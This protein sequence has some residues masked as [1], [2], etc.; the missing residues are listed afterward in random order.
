MAGERILVV[1]DEGLIQQLCRRILLKNG[2]EVETA[3]N[4]SHALEMN[5][6]SSYDILLTDIKMPGMSG[7]ELIEKVKERQPEIAAIVITGY[8]SVDTA[9]ESLKLGVMGFIIKPFTPDALLVTI[10]NVLE[11]RRILSENTRLKL[12]M[13][14]F[15]VTRTLTSEVNQK[16]LLNL[17][18]SYAVKETK[19]EEGSLL[20]MDREG[21]LK[22]CAA[23]DFVPNMTGILE[24]RVVERIA[25]WT[26]QHSR[27]L[28]LHRNSPPQSGWAD[29][30]FPGFFENNDLQSILSV[31]L[32]KKDRA[33]GV[34][35][36]SKLA[37][38][39]PF[40]EA[41]MDLITILCGQAAVA[42]ENARL[43]MELQ[44]KTA[45]LEEAIFDTMGALSQALE[46]RDC[47]VQAHNG[48]MVEYAQ[49]VGEKLKLSEDDRTKLRYAILILD[50]GNIGIMDRILNK[51]DKLQEKE[52]EEVKR[53]V[54]LSTQI[55]KRIKFLDA[56]TPV[57]YHHHERWDGQGYPGG[58]AG[59]KIPL[60]SRIVA[61]IDAFDAMISDRPYRK[62]MSISEATAELKCCA[63]TQ[64]D[65]TVV[66]VF[67]GVLKNKAA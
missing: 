21:E 9:I 33:I 45:Y 37:N 27:P 18:L 38:A 25:Q 59:E 49:E 17:I 65:P 16:R 46:T 51:P 31:P 20:I 3:S 56:V 22:K 1:D 62:A 24:D 63:G 39:I 40:S 52:Y 10:Q 13:P 58:L 66:E 43:F 19:A 53:H 12:L 61:V 54:L 48:R 50:I 29:P 36:L 67:L 28:L 11:K 47:G 34:L 4:G 5:A 32:M 6:K 55:V 41:D 14:L 23:T 64:F 60:C 2:F 44:E 57:I 8:G 35:N 15:D 30:A 7:L 42:I 26:I